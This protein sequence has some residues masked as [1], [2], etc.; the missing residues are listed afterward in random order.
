MPSFIAVYQREV[1]NLYVVLVEDR[2]IVGWHRICGGLRVH[3]Q[4]KHVKLPYIFFLLA[5]YPAS[6]DAV[7]DPSDSIIYIANLRRALF[8]SVLSSILRSN[9][10]KRTQLRVSVTAFDLPH[11]SHIALGLIHKNV[12]VFFYV[13]FD[14]FLFLF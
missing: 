4:K 14:F 6:F 5:H 10:A 8:L 12:F 11:W 1:K 13:Q 7:F 3:L 2:N 9:E